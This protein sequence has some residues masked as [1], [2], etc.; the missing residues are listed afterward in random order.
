MIRRRWMSG[1]GRSSGLT[2]TSTNAWFWIRPSGG[3]VL[4]PDADSISAAGHERTVATV[5]YRVAYLAMFSALHT[6]GRASFTSIVHHFRISY[7]RRF[8]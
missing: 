3:A 7:G 8:E 5:R 4:G 2:S 6:H 1:A